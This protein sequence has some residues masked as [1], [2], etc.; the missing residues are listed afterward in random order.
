MIICS[1]ELSLVKPYL[2]VEFDHRVVQHAHFDGN[3]MSTLPASSAT[4]LAN[5]VAATHVWIQQLMPVYRARGTL[6]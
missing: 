3:S 4:I 6:F 1:S 2:D 5:L